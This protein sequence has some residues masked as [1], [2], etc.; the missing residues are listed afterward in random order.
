MKLSGKTAL[1]T[2]GTSGI[3]LSTA[4]L[5]IQQGARVAVTGRNQSKFANIQSELGDHALVLAADVRSREDMQSVRHRLEET[6][7]GLDI[8]FANA[9]IVF[10]S[11]LSSTDETRY[12]E[13]MDT[14]VKGV[15]LSMQAVG[16]I[17]ND[18]GAVVLN[19]SF[20]NQVGS[21]GL[22]LVSASK[23]A[24]RSFARSW[25]RELLERKIRVNTV[26]PGYIDTPLQERGVA[27]P[28]EFQ[29]KK[30]RFASRVPIGRMGKAEEIAQAVLFLASDE[31]QYVV[32]AELVVDGGV[33][34]L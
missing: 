19:T 34:Q 1:I 14:N 8:F 7:G 15:F 29:A 6:F 2:G 33:S 18:G 32:G 28:E 10:P 23:A 21:P 30:E 31:S 9:G 4:R 3:G 25:S 20:L 24:L 27:S 26:S 13:I 5:F 22:S 11:L 17:L 12:D 16:P